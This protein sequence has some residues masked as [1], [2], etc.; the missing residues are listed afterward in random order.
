M[1]KLSILLRGRLGGASLLL[2]GSTAAQA[3]ALLFSP[4]LTRIYAPGEMGSFALYT[5]AIALLALLSTARYDFAVVSPRGDAMARV[6]VKLVTLIS[7]VML[8]LGATLLIGW[9]LLFENVFGVQT[10]HPWLWAVPLG[11]FLSALQAGYTAYL[12]RHVRYGAI[13]T[14]RVTMSAWSAV[15]SVTLGWLHF[16]V[17]GLLLSSLTTL[18]IAATLTWAMSG[19][20]WWPR[21][22]QRRMVAVAKRY[23]NYPRIDLPS[24]LFG[25]VGSQL[26]TLLLG[27]F[28][29]TSFLGF[30]AIVDRV[31]LAPLHIIGGAV[32]SVFRVRATK[33]AAS[34]GEF[35]KEYT[36]TFVLLLV[37]AIGFFVPM[38]IFGQDIFVVIF[39]VQWRTAGQ[40]AQTLAPLY[41][42][43]LLASPLSMSL[44]VRNRM[45]IDL[46]GQI[47][48]AV[49][50]L[51][52]MTIGWLLGDPWVALRLIVLASSVI[53]AGYLAY[54]W[55][56]SRV[57]L[58]PAC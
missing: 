49:S 39:G 34:T 47:L 53:Y 36:R 1:N 10:E 5:S 48:L 45:K 19:L 31:F 32:G 2:I 12:L 17:W 6:L 38:M 9:T 4:V 21:E 52:S 56:I 44:Y 24:S 23:I 37:P 33:L 42:I 20:P 57:V 46:V 16:G 41:F 55:R 28:F 13:A 15:L 27:A 14:A 30:Y 3:I 43:R 11:V 7:L 8:A 40:I 54:G 26:P 50:S 25:V 18:L 35:S 29:G 58:T 22:S 51:A